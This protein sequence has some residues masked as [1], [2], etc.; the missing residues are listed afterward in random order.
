MAS[1]EPTADI[2]PGSA[3]ATTARLSAVGVSLE[4]PGREIGPYKLLK[5]LGEGGFGSVWLADQREPVQRRVALKVLKAGM[6]TREV[7]IRFEA[8]RQALALMNHPNI[9]KV[10][11]AGAT[12]AGRPY[13]VMEHVAGVPVNEY[14]D[15]RKLSPRDRLG[16]F[17]EICLAVQ[18]AHQKGIIHRDLK[19]G[20]ILVAEVDGKPAPKVIDFGIAKAT[21]ARLT[22]ETLVTETGRL[23]GTPEYMS[24]EQVGGVG[25]LDID[26]RTDVYSLGVIL[27]ELMTGSLPFDSKTLRSKGYDG[28][29]RMIKESEPPRPSTRL[30]T[31]TS[32]QS[33]AATKRGLDVR[34]LRS[35]LRGDLDWIIARAMEK[36]R[37]RR[38]SS[39]SEL[40]ADVER[41]LHSE[42]VVA[43]PPSVSYRVQKFVR[44]NRAFVATG[45]LVGAVVLMGLAGT[46]FGMIEA[47]RSEQAA[48]AERERAV[49]AEQAAVEQK[50]E[51]QREAAKALAAIEFVQRMIAAA[52]PDSA[53]APDLRV[54]EVLEVAEGTLET[55]FAQQPE[56]QAALRNTIGR[57]YLTLGL[58]D[59]AEPM[60]RRA[61]ADRER[62]LGA[63]HAS[64]AES[65]ND[66]GRTLH[67]RGEY[68]QAVETL[69]RALAERERAEGAGGA[70]VG[71]L[72]V[73]ATLDN[74]A[75][76]QYE[77]GDLEGAKV[78]VERAWAI[79]AQAPEARWADRVNNRRTLA[80]VQVG[81]GDVA[82]AERTLREMLPELRERLGPSHRDIAQ[83]LNNLGDLLRQEG[84]LDEADALLT[85]AV[86]MGESTLPKGHPDQAAYLSSLALVKQVRG[87][88]PAAA[89]LLERSVAIGR[90]SE[91]RAALS[92]LD[93]SLRNLAGVLVDLGQHARG[94]ELAREAL[95]LGQKRLG[96]GGG[97]GGGGGEN[98]ELGFASLVIG[99][100]EIGLDRG[101]EAVRTL[102]GVVALWQ[103]ALPE[104]D[105]RTAI[106]R[107]VL[108]E[109]LLK[110]GE[111]A[112]A[113]G[114]LEP[115]Y[116]RI[117]EAYGPA[118][119]RTKQAAA[120]MATLMN[121]LGDPA[122]AAE[123]ERAASGG[124]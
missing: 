37:N 62:L 117:L 53:T 70:A 64:V 30:A 38:Y 2:S 10:L 50:T 33:V 87:D 34:S 3:E 23:M 6:D 9:A 109:A 57:T 11:D 107:S 113:R 97:G 91:E 14:C 42:P 119:L 82:A 28:L 84:K 120:R 51:A 104:G 99:R 122:K 121:R 40:A 106:A 72:G 65:R 110:T 100:A 46:S 102:R 63:D 114:M 21:N 90:G 17:V 56:V 1:M 103:G 18:H 61:L 43:R 13:F 52:S 39:A 26:S 76:V 124:R 98:P 27:Y 73:A 115:A 93:V 94:L 44:R 111:V 41:F 59:K 15:A 54:R 89:A 66:L 22:E 47:R 83:T 112:E 12:G 118:H 7:L 20:N 25:G 75:A 85:E 71:G 60:I 5:L 4:A 35:Q 116:A 19:P 69:K 80:A 77:M 108:G 8:E 31:L 16:M 68:A 48:V 55:E 86:S 45:A 24:P 81:L 92:D 123:F 67:R 58:A 88:L 29:I 74:L 79:Y 36:D 101:A 32:D 105:V 78:S 95:A 96:V 49:Q